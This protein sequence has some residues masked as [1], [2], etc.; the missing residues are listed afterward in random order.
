MSAPKHASNEPLGR[1]KSSYF[2]CG[3][4]NFRSYYRSS[5]IRV[6]WSLTRP[7]HQMADPSFRS[8]HLAHIVDRNSKYRLSNILR[9]LVWRLCVHVCCVP[10]HARLTRRDIA[11]VHH[12][13][14]ITARSSERPAPQ[15]LVR[16]TVWLHRGLAGIQAALNRGM[17]AKMLDSR[18]MAYGTCH[19]GGVEM[20]SANPGWP[21]SGWTRDEAG[22]SPEVPPAPRHLVG[23][24]RAN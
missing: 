3:S 7:D 17:P 2:V 21:S 6:R 18:P 9:T 11:H 10:A 12:Q 22:V 14:R 15:L 16:V 23:T 4:G 13:S 5:A 19:L 24:R 1:R 20:S 8:W